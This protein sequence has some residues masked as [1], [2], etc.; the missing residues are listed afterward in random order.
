MKKF[1]KKVYKYR[2]YLLMLL[3]AVALTLVFAYY[4]MPGI[5]LA[6]KKVQRKR[7][8]LGKPLEWIGEL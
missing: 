7:W 3:P 6:F 8:N 5:V 2:F 1:V 4:P